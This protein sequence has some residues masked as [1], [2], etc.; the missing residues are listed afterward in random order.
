MLKRIFD[1]LVSLFGLIIFSPLFLIIAILIKL[2]SEGPVFYRGERI[3]KD[4]KPFRI[5]K[6]RTM[7]KNAEELGGP[8]TSADDPRLTKI[9]KF[10]RKYKL[11]ELPQLINV[12]KGEMSLV[13][14]RP[15][16]KM[17]VDMLKSEEK[18]KILSLKPGMTDLASLWDFHEEE[19]LKG[20]KDPEKTYME[21]IRPKKIQLQLEYVKNRSFLLDLK[22]IFKTLIRLIK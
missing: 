15:E 2:D 11:D 19:V 12:L 9:G 8:S 13:G 20:S 4:G 5:F 6:F 3:G 22:I 14:P 1:F 16:V 7:V 21:K 10:L 18:E 17:Y